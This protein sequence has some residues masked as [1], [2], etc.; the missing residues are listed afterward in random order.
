MPPFALTV[1]MNLPMSVW[2]V[3]VCYYYY[4]YYSLYKLDRLCVIINNGSSV[5][6][7]YNMKALPEYKRNGV[8][9]RKF[10]L[11]EGDKDLN[12]FSESNRHKG[13]AKFF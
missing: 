7:E 11:C 3:L 6:Y 12:P 1:K 13:F 2:F 8:I 10:C 5:S 9:N 4:H